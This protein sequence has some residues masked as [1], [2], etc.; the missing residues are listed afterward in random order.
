[1][2]KFLHIFLSIVISLA[3]MLYSVEFTR[4]ATSLSVSMTDSHASQIS[5]YTLTL[6]FDTDFRIKFIYIYFYKSMSNQVPPTTINLDNTTL[7]SASGLNETWYMDSASTA[8]G[9]ISMIGQNWVDVTNGSQV[10]M[11][12]NSIYNPAIG[13]CTS[14]S[15]AETD[16]CS[17]YV[18]CR[19]PIYQGYASNPASVDY[20]HEWIESRTINDLAVTL[21]PDTALQSSVHEI[22]FSTASTSILR[23]IDIRYGVSAESFDTPPT[24]FDMSNVSISARTGLNND[25]TIDTVPSISGNYIKLINSTGQNFDAQASIG[26]TLSSI[27]NPDVGECTVVG[28]SYDSCRLTVI[29]RYLI[30]SAIDVDIGGCNYTINQAGGGGGAVDPTLSFTLEGV[31]SGVTNNGVTTNV[32]SSYGSL[33][34]GKLVDSQPKFACQK[35]T[36]VTNATNGYTVT[37]KVDGYIQGLNTA[38]KIDPF[39]APGVSWTTPQDWITPTGTTKSSDSGWFGANTTD[40]RVT[41]WSSGTSGKFGPISST[42]R[43]VMKSTTA[44]EGT[45]IYVSYAI[46]INGFQPSDIYSGRLY[47]NVLATY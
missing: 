17:I 24:S 2:K 34:F 9:M 33:D 36:V 23:E 29:T 39:G 7:G 10:V 35:L 6:T 42:P 40:T 3:T 8:S 20:T 5:N 26:I 11:T 41:G 22:T 45:S 18:D 30:D 25:W 28:E 12:F 4:A 37:V 14:S 46:E 15:G 27:T 44:D 43:V 19:S 47:Y 1:M 13:D 21:D 38:N 31:G 16:Q 32:S